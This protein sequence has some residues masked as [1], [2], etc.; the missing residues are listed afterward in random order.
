MFNH[1][2]DVFGYIGEVSLDQVKKD[3]C[4]EPGDYIGINGLE[5]TYETHTSGRERKKNRLGR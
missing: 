5:R 3:T 1:S 4:Y 2:A